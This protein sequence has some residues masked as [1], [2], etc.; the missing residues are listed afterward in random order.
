MKVI[1]IWE[2]RMV[3]KESLVTKWLHLEKILPCIF[4]AGFTEEF[5]EAFAGKDSSAADLFAVMW[6]LWMGHSQARIWPTFI[7]TSRRA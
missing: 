4:L 1:T 5:P 7:Q 2:Y 3:S 6:T